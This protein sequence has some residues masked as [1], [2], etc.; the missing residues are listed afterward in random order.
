MNKENQIYF[1][2]IEDVEKD[3]ST[4]KNKGLSS[5]NAKKRLEKYG[6]NR[7][8]EKKKISMWEIFIRQFKSIVMLL[9]T[10]AAIASFF[11][12]E[13]VEGIAVLVVILITAILGLI[14]EYKAGKSIEALKKTVQP[15]AKVIRNGEISNIYTRKIVVGDLILLEEGDK[16]PAD[17]RLVEAE[18]LAV[19]EAMLTGE[20]DSVEKSI[21]V[22]QSEEKVDIA[23]QKNMVFMGSK[24]IKG[25]GKFLVT[26]TGQEAQIGKISKML[27]ETEDEDTPLE[28][29]LEQTGRYL[30]IITLIITGIVAFIGYLT[31]KPLLDML[32]TS[33]ALAIAAVPEGLPAAATI[34]LAI[35]MNRMAKK[36]ALMRNLP[37]VETLGS[38]T[39]FCVDKTGTLTE[40]EMT[41]QKII[42][43]NR[44]IN[45][46]GVGY[47]PEGDFSEGN[48][49]LDPT[50]D[51]ALS[52]ILK[53]GVLCSEAVLNKNEKDQWEIIGDPTEGSLIVA[54]KKA[55]YERQ[56]L[57]KEYPREEEIPFDPKR[58]YMA[59]ISQTPQEDE[60]LFL[61]GAPE[62]VLD[63]CDRVYQNNE[64][65]KLTDNKKK[66]LQNKNMQLAKDSFR[67]LAIAYKE[68]VNDDIGNEVKGNLIFL[69]FVGM[70]DPPREGVKDS[71]EVASKAGIR[72]IMLTGDQKETAISIAKK[73]GIDNSEYDLENNTDLD[74]FSIEELKE[75]LNKRSVFPRV[76]PKDKLNVINALKEKNEIV[77]M[78]GDGVNDAPALKK[79]DIGVSMGV[80][81]TSVAK[82]A[83]DMVLLDDRFSTIVEAV[84]QGRVIFDNIQK[85][86]H[87][88]LSCN[89][90]EII[91][92]FLS[93]IFGLP[94]PLVA[95]QILWLN[96]ATGV[97]PALAMA[98]EKPEDKVMEKKPRN[99]KSP[100]ITNRYKFL[101]GFQG[102]ILA[103]GPLISYMFSLNQGFE[104][105]TARTIGFMTLAIVHLL[106]VFNVR[107]KNG[108]G[109]DKTFFKN[110]YLIGSL[111]LTLAL[112]II[113]VYTPFLQGILQTTALSLN[114]WSYVVIGAVIPNIF[115]QLIAIFQKKMKK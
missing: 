17:G 46:S 102:L 59:I 75:K 76:A 74:E 51:E 97:F 41:L 79:A 15:K 106:Q 92:I 21:E 85:F 81:G 60:N 54:A 52:L 58:K 18:N 93:I 1:K 19:D 107:R 90:S 47:K 55:G 67:V 37:A 86:I 100:I 84:R 39:V 114:M 70:I 29:R 104:L 101:I 9:L 103:I 87:Y 82:E 48:E 34:T 35:G 115:L 25:N 69:G 77:A 91:F 22:L 14:M 30:I 112:Q 7:L 43:G 71:I 113:A 12:G 20:S 109:Y 8:A 96:V 23:D 16:I 38:S 3:F 44:E 49:K 105:A 66:E 27:Q 11:I 28:K 83:S 36:K 78:T 61:K 89:F 13:V 2:T 64:I 53:I 99:P 40:N 32:K 88:L 65:I 45:V 26:S 95:L 57:E 72:T 111:V 56:N 73:I 62:V 50:K 4:D 68:D 63:M 5:R 108:L 110:P 80:R 42:V 6:Q 24:V 98:W 10:A 31:G 94:T 33:I